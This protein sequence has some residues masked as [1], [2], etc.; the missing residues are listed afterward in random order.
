MDL[1]ELCTLME[2]TKP[3]LGDLADDFSQIIPD[4]C[5]DR[6]KLTDIVKSLI[7]ALAVQG[8]PLPEKAQVCLMGGA[9]FGYIMGY[10][11]AQAAPVFFVAPEECSN[12]G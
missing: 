9:L 6:H 4:D 12:D 7:G 3:L 2:D 5:A 8:I 11:K 1:K 10:R